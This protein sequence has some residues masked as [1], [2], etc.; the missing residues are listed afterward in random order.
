M[1]IR[2]EIKNY[3][4]DIS[5]SKLLALKPLLFALADESVIIERDLT[6]EERALIVQGMAEYESNPD[7]FIPLDSIK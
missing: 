2:Q 1:T 4:D 3:I 6:A 5:E 7:S